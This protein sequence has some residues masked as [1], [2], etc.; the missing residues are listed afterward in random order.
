MTVGLKYPDRELIM[1]A[2]SGNGLIIFTVGGE[3]GKKTI[4][5]GLLFNMQNICTYLHGHT[6]MFTHFFYVFLNKKRVERRVDIS[7][8]TMQISANGLHI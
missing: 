6:L 1:L 5:I 3:D 2:R 7:H 4:E 8:V